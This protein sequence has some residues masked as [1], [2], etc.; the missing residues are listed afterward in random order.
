MRFS[1]V[2]S[3]ILFAAIAI[4]ISSGAVAPIDAAIRSAVH[5]WS[6]PTLTQGALLASM[7]G[8]VGITIACFAAS[9][10]WFWFT[11]DHRAAIRLTVTM[12]LALALDL[13]TKYA[14]HRTRPEPFF[15]SAPVSYSFPSGHALFAVALWP[16]LI[17]ETA[18]DSRSASANILL[19][20]GVVFLAGSIGLSRIYL[21]VHYPS[22]VAAG[23]IAGVFALAGARASLEYTRFARSY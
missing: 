10:A 6:S 13:A 16:T 22:D 2:V 4:A 15:G 14:F 12:S 8:G 3:G 19:W 18:R 20:S 7:I 11:G 5:G 21:G 1:A 17:L 23:F 9:A